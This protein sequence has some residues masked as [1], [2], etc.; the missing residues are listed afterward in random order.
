MLK[1]LLRTLI[2]ITLP[3]ANKSLHHLTDLGI[4][5]EITG[6]ARNKIYVY[7]KYLDILSDG[8]EPNK[9]DTL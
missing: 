9:E 3:H 2:K 8:V 4:V 5:K 1:K 6:K 7:Q